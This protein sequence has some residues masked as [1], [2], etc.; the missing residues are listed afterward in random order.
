M[1]DLVEA[2]KKARPEVWDFANKPVE[3][4]GRASPPKRSRGLE[5]CDDESPRKRTRSS[6]RTRAKERILVVD[7]AEDDEDYVPG[8]VASTLTPFSGYS[9]S[10]A[11]EGFVQC[12]VCQKV[13]KEDTINSHLDRNCMDE[14]RVTKPLGGKSSKPPAST[15]GPAEKAMKRP[16]RLPQLHYSMVKDNLLRKK[17]SDLGL[18]AGGS[19]QLLEKRYTE[20]VTLWN[21]NCDATKPKSKSELRRELDIWERTQGSKA[22]SSKQDLGAQIKEKDFD[23]QAWSSRHDDS[24]R[25][26]IAN[27]RKKAAVKPPTPEPTKPVDLNETPT[28]AKKPDLHPEES[29][30]SHADTEMTYNGDLSPEQ[31]I[32]EESPVK[33]SPQR[34]FFDESTTQLND[35]SQLPPSSQYSIVDKDSG[36]NSDMTTLKPLQ[37]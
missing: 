31:N 35:P 5:E 25:Q 15:P 33:P 32:V 17:L 3:D 34:R 6:G 22:G 28:P 20:W 37:P 27:A 1:E 9:N 18:S 8:I 10:L 2:F 36:I 23:G 14:P 7:S 30:E 13:V 26:L 12:P 4:P 21:A 16:E 11:E 24:F 29:A 19:R